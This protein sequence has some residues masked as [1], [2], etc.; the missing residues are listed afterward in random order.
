MRSGM[1]MVL[2]ATNA[3]GA[4]PWPD[5]EWPRA[6][7]EAVGLAPE[8]LGAL[9]ADFASGK[10]PLIDSF[11]V[12]RCGAIVYE[13]TYP[14]DYGAI[15][16]KQAHERGPLNPHLTGPYN[17]FDPF[18]HPYFHGSGAHSMQSISKTVTATT[19]GIAIA[20][21]DF[22]ASL[23]TPVLQFFDV[24]HVKNVDDRKRRMT[25]R[26]VLTMTT[27]LDWN[28]ELP[29]NDPHNPTA[30]MEASKDWVGFVIDLPMA[31]EPGSTFA[32]S[33]GATEL[34][35]HI[36]KR[37][38]GQDIEAYAKRFLF[39]PLGIHEY[40]WKR[41]PLGVVD[42]EGGLFL[43]SED[44]A[45]I[46]YLYLRGGQWHG[47]QLIA[48][49]FLKEALTPHIDTGTGWKYVYQWWLYPYDSRLLWT[50]RGIGGQLL[51]ISPEDDLIVVTTAWDILAETPIFPAIFNKM[52]AAVGAHDCSAK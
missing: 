49:E 18:W 15:Y 22:K 23:D 4:T 52:R 28:E 25:L 33:S 40:H 17:Y 34:L 21:G 8:P 14:H 35:A 27:G 31:N 7:P 20:R 9:D 1:L 11:L 47:E 32:Y 26:N 29:Y 36:F 39:E 6:A 30:P 44:L 37:A 43:T 41:T 48:P 12:A 10:L 19:I 51:M 3:M 24:R 42:T 38:T 2:L 13:R 45:R 16:A 5:H 50:A 46:G